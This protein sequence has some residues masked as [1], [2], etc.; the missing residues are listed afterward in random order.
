MKKRR[1]LCF[2]CYEGCA[3]SGVLWEEEKR[4]CKDFNVSS[5]KK[6]AKVRKFTRQDT[7][8]HLLHLETSSCFLQFFFKK[9]ML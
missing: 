2:F 6:K 8:R 9:K 4:Q 7:K 1:S 5:R 3:V